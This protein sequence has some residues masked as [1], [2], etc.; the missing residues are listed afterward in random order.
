MYLHRRATPL[1][2]RDL[3]PQN[4]MLTS[5]FTGK[6]ADFGESKFMEAKNTTDGD[7]EDALMTKKIENMNELYKPRTGQLMTVRGTPVF[8]APEV[9]RA[10]R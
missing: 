10:E 1:V 5:S 7:D 6:I 8:M 3:K 2:H 9:F 4:I